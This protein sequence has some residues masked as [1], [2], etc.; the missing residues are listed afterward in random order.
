M[1]TKRRAGRPMRADKQYR[2]KNIRFSKL[3]DTLLELMQEVEDPT[4]L[5]IIQTKLKTLK[6][7]M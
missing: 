5:K 4:S 6:E 3:E 1:E 2:K 7:S